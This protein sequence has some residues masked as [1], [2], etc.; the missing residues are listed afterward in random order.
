MKGTG[1]LI[2]RAP[3]ALGC[4]IPH[5]HDQVSYANRR[6]FLILWTKVPVYVTLRTHRME[7]RRHQC[8]YARTSAHVDS[9][10]ST[11]LCP[12]LMVAERWCSVLLVRLL[13]MAQ[14]SWDSRWRS[15]F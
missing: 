11:R 10:C 6:V 13:R 14:L 2:C 12:V 3:K 5:R 4:D 15:A 9:V 8:I 1:V 7:D